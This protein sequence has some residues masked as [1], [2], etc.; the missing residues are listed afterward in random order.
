MKHIVLLGVVLMVL[1][2]GTAVSA[3]TQLVLMPFGLLW[4][5]AFARCT[6]QRV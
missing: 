4:G 5:A 3:V 6:G 1:I 2:I